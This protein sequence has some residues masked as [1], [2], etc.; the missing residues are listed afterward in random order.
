MIFS[1]GVHTFNLH[2]EV[3]RFDQNLKERGCQI[4][5]IIL[6]EKYGMYSIYLHVIQSTY[7]TAHNEYY[8]RYIYK[9]FQNLWGVHISGQM[10]KGLIG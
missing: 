7:I 6:R 10:L 4:L 2:S 3:P 1:G 9:H 8:A 5:A